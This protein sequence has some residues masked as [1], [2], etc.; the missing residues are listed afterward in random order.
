MMRGSKHF[1][2]QLKLIHAHCICQ[3]PVEIYSLHI[4]DNLL[5]LLSYTQ[6]STH[7]TNLVVLIFSALLRQ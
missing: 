7:I 1:A 4:S 5:Q 3:K 2:T 6:L